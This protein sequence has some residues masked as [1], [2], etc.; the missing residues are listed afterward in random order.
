MDYSIAVNNIVT[1][2]DSHLINSGGNCQPFTVPISH[3]YEMCTIVP[4]T[5]FRPERI[6]SPRAN[7]VLGLQKEMP[8]GIMISFNIFNK[9]ESRYETPY[10]PKLPYTASINLLVTPS[11]EYSIRRFNELFLYDFQKVVLTRRINEYNKMLFSLR[12][13]SYQVHFISGTGISIIENESEKFIISFADFGLVPL[14]TIAQKYTLAK[15]LSDQLNKDG[16]KS[17]KVRS[18]YSDSDFEWDRK[19]PVSIDIYSYQRN[20]REN[21][22]LNEW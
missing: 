19:L 7:F 20:V 9:S 2:I 13:S 21:K 5:L 22:I 17:Y 4:K 14:V 6:E 15:M 3:P 8:R 11:N 18:I 12:K 16:V 1:A 10:S